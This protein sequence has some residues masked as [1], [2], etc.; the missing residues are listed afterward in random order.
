MHILYKWHLS[1]QI[2]MHSKLQNKTIKMHIF[3]NNS[4]MKIQLAQI[5]TI[6]TD[7]EILM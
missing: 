5:S 4:L 3:D 7:N 2:F 6:W 1:L